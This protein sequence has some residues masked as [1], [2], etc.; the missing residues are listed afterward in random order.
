MAHRIYS[1]VKNECDLA[2]TPPFAFSA[3]TGATWPFGKYE[4]LSDVMVF[5]AVTECAVM[6]DTSVSKKNA[7]SSF[8]S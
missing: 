2:S 3:W 5:L 4:K 6:S 8:R 7:A 1:N